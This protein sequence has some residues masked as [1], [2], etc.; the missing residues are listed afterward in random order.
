MTYHIQQIA[1]P[2]VQMLVKKIFLIESFFAVST[3]PF[4]Y[5]NMDLV[6]FLISIQV[7]VGVQPTVS[8]NLITFF[9]YKGCQILQWTMKSSLIDTLT[10]QVFQ[11]VKMVVYGD[12]WS[13]VPCNT[14][15]IIFH[16]ALL[17][18]LEQCIS[19][20]SPTSSSR[21]LK[22]NQICFIALAKEDD[23]NTQTAILIFNISSSL[24]NFQLFKK[25]TI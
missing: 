17:L 2:V 22:W 18:S 9:L 11:F 25:P 24:Y 15:S 13:A 1:M 14:S 12:S 20:E 10:S 8:W 3:F 5:I 16:A 4:V 21:V 6:L 19:T 7:I 23:I